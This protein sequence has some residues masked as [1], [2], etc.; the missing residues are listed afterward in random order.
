M[1]KHHQL[2]K[3]NQQAFCK[4]QKHIEQIKWN[5][6]ANKMEQSAFMSK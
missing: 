6:H 4:K 1:P 3:Q 2:Q 5:N